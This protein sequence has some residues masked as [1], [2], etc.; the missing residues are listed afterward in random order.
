VIK[1]KNLSKSLAPESDM[2]KLVDKLAVY[3]E[4]RKN[5]S[6]NDIDPRITFVN[7]CLEAISQRNLHKLE[8]L[9]TEENI[10]E[11]RGCFTQRLYDTVKPFQFFS[12]KRQEEITKG[13]S[14]LPKILI[15]E[16][17]GKY[18]EGLHCDVS[19]PHVDL[20]AESKS[21]AP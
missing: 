16:I 20:S 19:D 11:F 7:S 2:Q 5:E 10:I 18:D 1:A 17:I 15:Q 3:I 13:A 6:V 8:T 14:S 9:L 21:L 4:L 12:S